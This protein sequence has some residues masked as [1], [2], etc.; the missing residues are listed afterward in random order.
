MS[1]VQVKLGVGGSANLRRGTR[2]WRTRRR[3]RLH[4]R[5]NFIQ[6]HAVLATPPSVRNNRCSGAVP[7]ALLPEF[8]RGGKSGRLR[9]LCFGRILP[10]RVND[11]DRVPAR[12]LLCSWCAFTRPCFCTHG[13]HRTSISRDTALQVPPPPSLSVQQTFLEW[14][15]E[16]YQG[17][18][19]LCLFVFV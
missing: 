11:S 14:A 1:Q 10:V 16:V 2:H 19:P 8:N 18:T 6:I 9:L 15:H 7:R 5:G 4:K 13:M 3:P 12:I 17:L